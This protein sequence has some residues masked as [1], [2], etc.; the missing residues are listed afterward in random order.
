M[1]KSEQRAIKTFLTKNASETSTREAA[2][3]M[4]DAL[5]ELRPKAITKT[6]YW[7][8]THQ[9]IPSSV[10]KQKKIKDKSNCAAC[11]KDFQYGNLD[12]MNIIYTP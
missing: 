9:D 4:L 2:V 8:E 3:K 1:T 7:R 12:D 11:H 6:P 10:Y 5:G